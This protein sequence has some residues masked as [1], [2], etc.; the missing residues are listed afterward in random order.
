MGQNRN[1]RRITFFCSALMAIGMCLAALP[2]RADYRLCNR[3][4]YVLD[5]ALAIESNGATATQGWFRILPGICT[6]IL[7]GAWTGERYFLHTRTPDFYGEVPDPQSISRM[8][9]IGRETFLIAGAE[10]CDPQSGQLAPFSEVLPDRDAQTTTTE[11][12]DINNWSLDEARRAA[13]QRLLDQAGYDAGKI[14][15]SDSTRTTG[16]LAA[17]LRDKQIGDSV[18]AGTRIFDVLID[19]AKIR[20]R[21]NGVTLCNETPHRVL[22][23][24][25]LGRAEK[26]STRGWF[27]LAPRSCQQVVTRPLAGEKLFAFA[28]AVDEGGQAIVENERKLV[29]DGAVSLCT[30]NFRFE[31]NQHGACVEKGLEN[32]MFKA[33]DVGREAGWTVRFSGQGW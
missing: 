23:A 22:A 20:A 7:S 18:L 12:T 9:C 33:I 16:A 6:T 21:E 30:K 32:T 17:F 10:N 29:W 27:D 5:A 1:R 14:D 4:S 13:I 2:A 24:I 3:T 8:F 11:L 31:I 28:E 15:G 26:I 19:A 25:G